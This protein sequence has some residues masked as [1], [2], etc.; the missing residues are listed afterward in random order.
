[1]TRNQHVLSVIGLMAVAAGLLVTM[2]V[3]TDVMFADGLRYIDQA[4]RISRG[5]VSE[6]LFRSIDHPG[7][8]LSIAA[9]H[10]VVRGEDPASWQRAAQAAS[11]LAGVL[12]VVPLYLVSIELFGPRIAWLCC[13]LF[14]LA[15]IPCRVMADALSESTFLLFWCWGLWAAIRFLRAGS[16]GWLPPT[17]AFGALAYLTRP[18]GLL[19]VAALVAS[20][21][22]MPLLPSTRMSR[23]RWWAAVGFL[24]IAPAFCIGPY[25]LVKGGVGSKPAMARILGTAPK[26]ASDSVDR[27]RPLD[28][29]QTA[30]ETYLRATRATAAAIVELIS[31]PLLPLAVLGF[32]GCGAFA[33]GPRVR[34]L[35]GWIGAGSI[36][37]LARLH[38]TCGYC[39]SRHAML[40]GLF[41]IPAAAAGIAWLLA[42]VATRMART[43]SRR[44]KEPT[45]AALGLAAALYFCWSGP[46]LIRPINHDSEGYRLAGEWLADRGHAPEEAKVVD[47]P[48]WALFYSRRGGYTFANLGEALGD[49]LARYVVVR[50][51]HLAGP[52]SYCRVFRD[53]VKDRKPIAQFPARPDKSQ[54][55]V[56]IF[57]RSQSEAPAPAVAGGEPSDGRV[58]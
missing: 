28:P 37:A 14:Y 39:T 24:A 51:A 40:L 20:L 9:V 30:A 35:L 32:V 7:Y 29:D 17:V 58:R 56:L 46:S 4:Q 21:L 2:M 8:P 16:P 23:P 43:D 53:L 49:P 31:I 45:V 22:A 13:L 38:A 18:E 34:L 50:E 33:G 26:A 3:R 1:M 6:G 11:V 5:N 55:R 10:L 47:A 12:L 42:E 57:D 44:V 54:C 25:V 48:G 15:P 19:L 41:L 52:W 27:S 36:L